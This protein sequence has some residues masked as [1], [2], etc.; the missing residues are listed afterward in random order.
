MNFKDILKAE[1]DRKKRQLEQNKDILVPNKTYFKRGD[2]V[3]KQEE[4]YWRKHKRLKEDT[5]EKKKNES[6]K[7]ANKEKN[8]KEEEE[9]VSQLPRK[10]VVRRLRERGEPI[11]LFGESDY[12][13]FQRLKKVEML[14]PEKKDGEGFRNDFKAAMDQV[15]QEYYDEIIKATTSGGSSSRANNVTVKDDGTTKEDIEKMSEEIGQGDDDKDQEIILRVLKLILRLWGEELNKR[16]EEE[17][18]TMKGKEA[19]AIHSQTVSYM[20]PLFRKLKQKKVD[21]DI[22]DSLA[23]I[24]KHMLDRH[25]IRNHKILTMIHI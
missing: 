13:A 17:K 24:V 1:V 23:I 18:R 2:L 22:K 10:E 7:D 12:E 16:P 6:A 14:M 25:Y 20:K 11:R 3:A 15:D 9:K 8:D 19:S 4:E 21:V 5:D